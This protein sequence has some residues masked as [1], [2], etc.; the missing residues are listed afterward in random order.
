TISR[1]SPVSRI[2]PLGDP[3]GVPGVHDSLFARTM[4]LF[5]GTHM[6]PGNKVQILSNGDQTYAPLWRDLRSARQTITVQMYFS[7]HGGIAPDQWREAN[8]RFEGP[9]VAQL[10]AAFAAGWAEATGEL[11]T[12]DVFFPS[13]MF[14]SA[15]PEVAGLLHSIPT[16]GSTPG[17][18]FMALSIAAA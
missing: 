2:V 12:G 17:E 6:G 18:R 10:Q 16:I 4:E 1:G 8:V 13:H 9:A 11:I 5:T 14:E 3:R 15:G 7:L